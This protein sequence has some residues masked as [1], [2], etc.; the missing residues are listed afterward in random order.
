MHENGERRG[1]ARDVGRGAHMA[2]IGGDERDCAKGF[3]A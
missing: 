3:L 1:E 2:L